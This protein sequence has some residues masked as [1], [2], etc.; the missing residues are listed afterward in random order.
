MLFLDGVGLGEDDPATNPFCAADLPAFRSLLNGHPPLFRTRD[1]STRDATMIPLDATLGVDGLPQ[2]GTGQTALFTGVNGARSI[3]KHF[4][5]YPYSTLRPV[6]EKKNIFRRLHEIGKTTLFANA[7]PQR[8]FDYMN[9]R[10]S[11]LTV[12]TLACTMSGVPLL[13]HLDLKEG[14]GISADIT[15]AGWHEMGYTD[16]PVVTPAEAG[17]R[18]AQLSAFHDFVLFEYWMTDHA[19]HSEDF[20]RAVE[21]LERF[22]GFLSGIIEALDTAETL[23]VLTSDHGNIENMTTKTHTRNPVPGL[24]YGRGHAAAAS[25]LRSRS[26]EGGDLTHV[27][28]VMMNILTDGRAD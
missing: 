23:L 26:P 1:S 22:D 17:R 9:H 24:F 28:P 16:L 15:N 19:G 4:G 11:H 25:S 10:R 8:F 6:I 21:V 3:G 7:F 20:A 13:K 18:L 27:T 14:R 2:S 5:P 12:T